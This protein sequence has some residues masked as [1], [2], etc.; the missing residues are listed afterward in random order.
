MPEIGIKTKITH[1][2][3]CMFMCVYAQFCLTLCNPMDCSPPSS[4]VYGI[5]QARIL[6]WIV[7][8]FSGGSYQPRD[9]TMC[10][11]LAGGFFTT[12]SLNRRKQII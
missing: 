8:S 6:E 10:P 3:V 7:I 4:S 1:T 11:S 2:Y 12:E 5:S 9:Q